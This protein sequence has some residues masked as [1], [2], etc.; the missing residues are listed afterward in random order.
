VRCR[1]GQRALAAQPVRN[2]S[3]LSFHMTICLSMAFVAVRAS[4]LNRLRSLSG[5]PF[6]VTSSSLEFAEK[7]RHPRKNRV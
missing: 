1:G 4:P 6:K 3:T 7:R 2:P 5:L